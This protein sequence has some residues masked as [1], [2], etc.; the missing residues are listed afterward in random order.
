MSKITTE[1]CKEAIQCWYEE[2]NKVQPG[3]FKRLKKFKN[4][5]GEVVRHFEHKASDTLL[6]VIEKPDY[7]EVMYAHDLVG[8]GYLFGF[9]VDETYEEE[10]GN[11]CCLF[12]QNTHPTKKH[13]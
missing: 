10:D 6:K 11:V 4:E 1:D 9:G 5:K 8:K 3:E 2:N 7:L 12:T 13:V